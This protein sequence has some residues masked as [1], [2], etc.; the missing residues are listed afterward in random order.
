MT[1]GCQTSSMACTCAI[2]PY[3]ISN[4]VSSHHA[5]CYVYDLAGRV[6]AEGKKAEPIYRKF[7]SISEHLRLSLLPSKHFP[8]STEVE[9]LSFPL[10]ITAT[11]GCLH[12]IAK[13]IWP[14]SCCMSRIIALTCSHKRWDDFKTMPHGWVTLSYYQQD[15]VQNMICSSRLVERTLSPTSILLVH[16]L[17]ARKQEQSEEY[18]RRLLP[19]RKLPFIGTWKLC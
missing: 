11:V 9:W 5:L 12:Y 3:C 19:K 13:S 10:W 2:M 4:D 14:G 6:S 1:F 16:T 15:I 18:I 8:L 17:L 7:F